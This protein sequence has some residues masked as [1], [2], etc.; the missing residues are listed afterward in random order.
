MAIRAGAMLGVLAV[1]VAGTIAGSAWL[2]DS[3][4][5]AVVP[6][7]PV[8]IPVATAA[9]VA[10][11]PA[12]TPAPVDAAYVVKR[13]LTIDGP[14][15]HGDYKWD[16]DGVPPGEVVVTVD[17]KAQTLSVFRGGYEIG[18]AVILYGGDDKPTPL[19]VFAVTEKDADHVSNLYG[20][21]MP[22]MLRLTNDG[23]AI[24]GSDVDV[25]L[26]THGCVGV[27]TK[28]AKLLFEQVKLGGRVIVTNGEM[29]SVGAPIK[30]A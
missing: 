19:G 3:P 14:F 4:A 6:A 12:A 25:G 2:A 18:A 15:R 23:I 13:V 7:K 28:F 9:T 17:L 24:H 1:L 26:M 27:P 30:A 11:E 8:V 20:A 21:P 5:V 16:D 10:V 22:Y 29:L